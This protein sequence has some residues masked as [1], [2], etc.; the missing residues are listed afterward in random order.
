[1]GL[2]NQL[3]GYPWSLYVVKDGY[4]RYAMH[5]HSPLGILGFVCDR[6]SGGQA[7]QAP[8]TLHMNFNKKHRAFELTNAHFGAHGDPTELLFAQLSS[9]D[10]RFAKRP[11]SEPDFVI[12]GTTTSLPIERELGGRSPSFFALMDEVFG[13]ISGSSSSIAQQRQ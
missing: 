9:I 12:A 2:L 1:M 6:F 4:L 13:S 3:F 11:Y 5:G 8:W 10:P 7:P